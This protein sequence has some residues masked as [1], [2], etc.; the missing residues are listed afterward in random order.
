MLLPASTPTRAVLSAS[1]GALPIVKSPLTIT[2][3]LNI[4]SPSTA[5]PLFKE[6]SPLIDIFP[7]NERSSETMR[8]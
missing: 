4:T 2:F 5:K 8:S 3:L 7:F 6:T 1:F